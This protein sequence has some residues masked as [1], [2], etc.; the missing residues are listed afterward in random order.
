MGVLKNAL[1][2]L[3]LS[4]L[5]LPMEVVKKPPKPLKITRGQM[6]HA[7]LS[8]I[9]RA[10]FGLPKQKAKALFPKNI[11][12]S[13]KVPT[14]L[15]LQ[16]LEVELY[17]EPN[18]SHPATYA[19][20]YVSRTELKRI[21]TE[22]ASKLRDEL[23]RI[24]ADAH[25]AE[26]EKKIT[27]AI[28]KYLST[29][30]LYEVLKETETVLLVVRDSGS[31]SDKA[32][33]KLAEAT[34]KSARNTEDVLPM[35]HIEVINRVEQLVSESVTSVDE[36]ARAVVFQL[37]KQARALEN[38]I[39]L[40]PVTYQDTKMASQFSPTTPGGTRDTVRTVR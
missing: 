33:A 11:A 4:V 28:E 6:S 24:L 13:S 3:I 29:Y 34:R 1:S 14:T 23:R 39:L 37:S 15:Q 12:G 20:A 8:L 22:R 38:K 18:R 9:Y 2:T 36:I 16:G 32:F 30:P 10:S 31:P 19:L 40:A 5:G 25:T 17:V 27:Q 35:S 7:K 21:Y 26:K